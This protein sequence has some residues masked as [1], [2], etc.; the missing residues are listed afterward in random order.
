VQSPHPRVHPLAGV[1][2][3]PFDS[4]EMGDQLVQPGEVDP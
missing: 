3:L 1:Q 4:G 2:Q